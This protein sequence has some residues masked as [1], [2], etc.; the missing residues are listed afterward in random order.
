MINIIVVPE[1]SDFIKS[2]IY[3][4]EV[5]INKTLGVP[6]IKKRNVKYLAPFWLDKN[7]RGVDRVFYIKSMK[8]NKIC[9]GNSF[10]LDNN[11]DKISQTR[12]FEYAHLESFGFIEIKDGILMKYNFK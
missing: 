2:T 1:T 8:N 12:K 10:V 4:L 9:L 6:Q 11:W 7:K 5:Y 3:S